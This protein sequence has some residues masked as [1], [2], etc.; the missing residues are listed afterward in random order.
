MRQKKYISKHTGRVWN[1]RE[2]A[3]K[4]NREYFTNVQYRYNIKQNNFNKQYPITNYTI[5][6]I[7]EKRITLHNAGLA[8]GSTF[9]ENLLDSIYDNAKRAGL[10]FKIALGLAIK[11]S[12]LNNPTLDI[13]N[14]AKISKLAANYIK[15]RKASLK[16]I[17]EPYKNIIVQDKGT[18][19]I[20]GRKLINYDSYDKNPYFSALAYAE[21][22]TNSFEEYKQRLIN[23]EAYSDKQAKYILENTPPMSILEAGFRRYKENPKEYNPGQFNYTTLVEKR[24]NEAMNS[25]EIKSFIKRKTLSGKY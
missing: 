4:D 25:P 21:R 22:K 5:P 20:S 18:K 1:T 8:S 10:P 23:G 14:I 3:I 12:T 2:E 9:S 17:E 7:P 6:Y 16:Q 11:E 15:K 13:E 19:P 24:G